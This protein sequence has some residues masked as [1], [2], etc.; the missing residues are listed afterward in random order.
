MERRLR[1]LTEE[2]TSESSIDVLPFST[3]QFLLQNQDPRQFIN[4]LE[5]TLKANEERMRS[6]KDNYDKMRLQEAEL[7]EARHVLRETKSFFENNAARSDS[8][9]I[10]GNSFEGDTRPLL[11]NDDLESTMQDAPG[12][13]GFQGLDLE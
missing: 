3:T 5:P 7:Q 1:F 11:D 8:T 12:S 4:E 2:I 9:T 13:S 6:I 10:R